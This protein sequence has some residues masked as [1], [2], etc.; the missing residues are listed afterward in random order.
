MEWGQSQARPT[1]RARRIEGHG[2]R[3][4]HQMVLVHGDRTE[5]P[6]KQAPRLARP[7]IDKAGVEPMGPGERESGRVVRRQ[8]Q[9]DG[10]WVS[11]D[12]L[13]QATPKRRR[14]SASQSLLKT[15]VLGQAGRDD[16]GYAGQRTTSHG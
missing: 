7:R 6:L 1:S 10:G 4:R 12:K 15:I 2:A 9:M 3:R 16:A 5:P 14:D 11:G 13:K 8:D